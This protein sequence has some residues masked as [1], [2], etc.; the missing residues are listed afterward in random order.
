MASAGNHDCA[1][2]VFPD[3]GV[4]GLDS[5]GIRT[6]RLGNREPVWGDYLGRGFWHAAGGKMEHPREDC[7]FLLPGGGAFEEQ[8]ILYSAGH[9]LCGAYGLGL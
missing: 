5:G 3:H 4:Y 7:A 2:P 6:G 9:R 8:G 1:G